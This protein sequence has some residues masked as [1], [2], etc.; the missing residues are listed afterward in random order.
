MINVAIVED[1]LSAA[2]RIKEY[3]S[4][5]EMGIRKIIKSKI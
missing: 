4:R 2:E 3:L 5:Y 1:E